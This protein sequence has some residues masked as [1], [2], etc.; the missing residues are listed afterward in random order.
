M[1]KSIWGKI[2]TNSNTTNKN[3]ETD[4]L[5]IGGGITGMTSL[6]YLLPNNKKTILIEA[7]KVGNGITNKT[8]GKIN[9]MQEYNYQKIENI[10]NNKTALKYLE[11]QIYATN[12]IKKIINKYN[13]NCD[14][15]KNDSYL[16]TNQ[17]EKINNI[18]KEKEILEKRIN[19]KT[20]NKLPNNYPCIFGIKTESYVFNP[21]KY[22]NK[23]K[24]ICKNNIYE[25]TRALTITKKLDYYLI[26]TNKNKIKAKTILIC[27]HYPFI[28]KL[29]IPFKTTIEKEYIISAHTNNPY[30]INM[31]SND[32]EIISIRYYKDNIIYTSNNSKL[33][34][35]LDH[36]KNINETIKNFKNH[37][38]YPINNTWYNCDIISN[39]YMPII[40]K[41]KNEN[42]LIATAFNKWGMTNGILAAKIMTDII[43]NKENEF[44]NLFDPYRKTNIKKIINNIKY[45][46]NNIKAYIKPKKQYNIKHIKEN[47]IE[48]AIYIDNNNKEHK[49]INKC[50]HM[51]C[52]LIFNELDKTWDCPCHGSR[53][54]IDGKIIKGPSTYSII[55]KRTR[56]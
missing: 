46:Y 7:N 48:Y 12:E 35:K 49:I 43:N 44:I 21:L 41:I 24:N 33:S 52:K 29:F 26:K 34:K 25:N 23:I 2:E 39:D 37:F 30:N 17:K 40:G 36:K 47:G 38:N 51:K 32:D 28:N 50:P 20:I 19:I 53:Y 45:N 13:I 1:N 9:I 6:L 18:L 4:I 54:T 5:I 15:E 27:T 10:T 8:T 3:I 11:S 22:I 42:I 31:I 55:I 14:L 16:F 56:K